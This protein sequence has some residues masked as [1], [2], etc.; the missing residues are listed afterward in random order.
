M[1]KKSLA[2][3]VLAVGFFF[4]ALP[5][6]IS[7]FFFFQQSYQAAVRRHKA[8]LKQ[9][10]ETRAYV[11]HEFVLMREQE[12]FEE[13]SS[14]TET[15]SFSLPKGLKPDEMSTWLAQLSDPLVNA[16]VGL[17]ILNSNRVVIAASDPKLVGQFFPLLALQKGRAMGEE[18]GYFDF[19]LGPG[20][21]LGYEE[22][23]QDL[24]LSMIAYT[25]KV[26]IFSQAIGHFL[27]LYSIYGI[28]LI[29]GAAFALWFTG[30]MA[31][32]FNQLVQVMSG[33][34]EGHNEARFQKMTL[35]FEINVLGESF[36]QMVEALLA[37]M[38][39]AEDERVLEEGYKKELEIGKSV[40]RQLLVSKMPSHPAADLVGLYIS[41]EEVGGD[42]YD[43][44]ILDEELYLT[45]ADVSGKGIPACLYSLGVRS[46]LRTSM[47]LT[48]DLGEILARS[49]RLFLKDTG[50]TGIY[51]T[52]LMGHYAPKT[53]LFSY[54]SCGHVPGLIRRVGG[55]VEVMPHQGVAMGLLESPRYV[56]GQVELQ[57]GDIV[58]FFT[59]GLIG[60]ENAKHQHF[61]IERLIQT[62]KQRR[63]ETVQE[64]V[65][66]LSNEVRAFMGETPQ[67]DEIILLGMQVR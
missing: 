23:V 11:L 46:L 48:R 59:D 53:H 47:R 1:I 52:V 60:A 18:A 41:S 5:L 26:Q 21:E 24:N 30:W 39:R 42:F 12:I 63:W 43:V 27:L 62:L 28:L 19:F 22:R 67:A 32:P 6:L 54:Y 16:S 36:N 33:V 65:D 38:Q 55:E 34:G 8:A 40:Q 58:L 13:I 9:V 14:A 25:P 61:T 29:V 4:I 31:R 17:A 15:G 10:A 37:A 66:G 7:S 64:I 2:L 35:G 44:Q 56:P 50:A 20:V 3:R 51:T 45:V 49:N 57:S